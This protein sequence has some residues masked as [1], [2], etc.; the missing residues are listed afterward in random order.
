M[1]I[2][3]SCYSD[4][5][6]ENIK[7]QWNRNSSSNGQKF[8]MPA[9][10]TSSNDNSPSAAMINDAWNY[11]AN[12]I[13]PSLGRPATWQDF[14]SH[15]EGRLMVL[16]GESV[17]FNAPVSDPVLFWPTKDNKVKRIGQYNSLNNKEKRIA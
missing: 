13:V 15:L 1:I 9:I 16:S 8:K 6:T 10:L 3:N 7:K 12:Y 4:K 14:W 2:F 5:F 11:F 17:H